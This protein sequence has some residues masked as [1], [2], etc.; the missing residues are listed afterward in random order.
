MAQFKHTMEIFNLL[1]KSNC[2]QCGKKTCLAFAATVFKGEKNLN[3]CPFIDNATAL[4]YQ[5]D[6]ESSSNILQENQDAFMEEM[7][8][9]MAGVNLEERSKILDAKFDGKWL[10]I[11]ILGRDFKIDQHGKIATTIHVNPWVAAPVFSYVLNA[12]GLEPTGK[13]VT[14]R[15][16]KGGRERYPLFRQRC[17]LPMKGVADVYTD[18]FNDMVTV[19]NGKEVPREFQSDISVVMHVL[20]RVP[21]M[22]CYWQPEDGMESSLNIYFDETADQNL[23]VGAI[24]SMG[25]GLTQMF[26][27]MALTHGSQIP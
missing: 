10:S 6:Y 7:R 25:A 1:N 19:L 14:F 15:D 9:Q 18:L 22:I 21:V 17:E 11:K 16:L 4:K 8:E 13:W 3:E 24:F 20:P 23:D 27:K 12:K 26:T 5:E 2:R